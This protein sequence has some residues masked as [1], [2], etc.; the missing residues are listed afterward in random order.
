MERKQ[1]PL[2]G[3][4]PGGQV[5]NGDARFANLDLANADMGRLLLFPQPDKVQRA[6][7]EIYIAQ[8]SADRETLEQLS[9]DELFRRAARQVLIAG[10]VI[11]MLLV[12]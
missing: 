10:A 7:E 6:W 1:N 4:Q 5:G 11:A 2:T 9:D 3:K 12:V 8:G